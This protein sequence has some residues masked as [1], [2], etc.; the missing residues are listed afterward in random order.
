MRY[1]LNEESFLRD[2]AAHQMKILRDDGLY[3]HIRFKRPD[4]GCMYFDLVTWPGLLCYTGDMGTYVFSRV[5]DMFEFFRMDKSDWNFNKNGLSINPGY[6]SEKL[7]AV[8]GNRHQASCMEFD[9]DRFRRVVN[10]YRVEWMRSGNLNKEERRELWEAVESEVLG[11][12]DNSGMRAQIAANDFHHM[13]GDHEF[14]FIDFW[15]HSFTRYTTHFLW[16][17]YALAW[18]IAQYDK[19]MEEQAVAA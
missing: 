14:C 9:E 4:S 16:C 19:H 6:W 11:E 10:K 3:R 7:Q 15:D 17:C 18:G 12:L 2:V 13:I 8:D 5:Q 1:Q